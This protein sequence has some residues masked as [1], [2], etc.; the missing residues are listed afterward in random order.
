MN[1]IKPRE[2]NP[3]TPAL[4]LYS[5]TAQ[6]SAQVLLR[7]YSTSFSL[8]CRML[9]TA[10]ATHI[11]NIYALVRLADEIVDGVAFK[12]GSSRARSPRAS[13]TW[14]R[15]RNVPWN[16]ATAP[17]WWCMPLRSPLVPPASRRR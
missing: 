12:P 15:K 13:M 1:A 11:A 6:R 17:I 7:Q 8:A 14:K 2:L 3:R 9:D 16:A 4:H 10:S 5:R